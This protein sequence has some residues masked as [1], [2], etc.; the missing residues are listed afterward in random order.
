MDSHQGRGRGGKIS[1]Q[2]FLLIEIPIN[3][4]KLSI[5]KL[6]GGEKNGV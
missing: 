3:T 5:T 6:K 4:K 1:P 2:A